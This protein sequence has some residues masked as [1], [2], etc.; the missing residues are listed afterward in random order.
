MPLL[1]ASR[2]IIESTALICGP[3]LRAKSAPVKPH[4]SQQP[5]GFGQPTGMPATRSVTAAACG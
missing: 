2:S 4:Q 3:L 5:R 1:P